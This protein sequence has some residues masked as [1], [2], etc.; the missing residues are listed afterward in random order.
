MLAILAILAFAFASVPVI[1]A[2]AANNCSIYTVRLTNDVDSSVTGYWAM[3]NIQR[4]VTVCSTNTPNTYTMT[5]SDNG[6][7]V[8]FAGGSPNGTGTVGN[9]VTGTIVGGYTLSVTGTI[10]PSAPSNLGTVDLQCDQAGNCASS[11]STPGAIFNSGYNAEYQDWGWTYTACNNQVWIN[12]AAANT[13]DIT[14]QAACPSKP[15]VK[16]TC[17]WAWDQVNG[18][19][20]DKSTALRYLKNHRFCRDQWE[21]GYYWYWQAH[22]ELMPGH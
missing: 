1:S 3:D 19:T 13:G 20:V 17:S 5:A 4:T 9:G 21:P 15:T 14:A 8:S 11:F 7:F 12:S 16:R 6:T 18:K 22:K 2:S 10:N